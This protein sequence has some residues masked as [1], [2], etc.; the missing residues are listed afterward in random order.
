MCGHRESYYRCVNDMLHN[1]DIL[2]S[3]QRDNQVP[4]PQT[5]ADKPGQQS[6]VT[7]QANTKG[8]R[9]SKEPTKQ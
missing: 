2:T 5:S 6:T 4:P 3:E 1:K 8:A 9:D 7:N